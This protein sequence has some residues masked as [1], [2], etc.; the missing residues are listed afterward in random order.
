MY[1][2]FVFLFLYNFLSPSRHELYNSI[3]VCSVYAAGQRCCCYTGSRCRKCCRMFGAKKDKNPARQM[4]I[5]VYCICIH[6]A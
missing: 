2:V 1:I 6:T 4:L 5:I 3:L